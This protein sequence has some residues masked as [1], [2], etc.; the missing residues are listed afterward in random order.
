MTLICSFVANS[1]DLSVPDII[2]VSVLCSMSTGDPDVKAI[3]PVTC[4]MCLLPN[5]EQFVLSNSS[6]MKQVKP[7][8][9]SVVRHNEYELTP[10]GRYD[11][12]HSYSGAVTSPLEGPLY[13]YMIHSPF[14]STTLRVQ[15]L[16]WRAIVVVFIA[17]AALWAREA[18]KFFT[19]TQ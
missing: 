3:G 11:T 7:V 4:T 18:W 13:C 16:I 8:L 5:G 15:K 2:V 17:T 14:Q 10:A 19:H 9:D 12:G 6:D 1:R